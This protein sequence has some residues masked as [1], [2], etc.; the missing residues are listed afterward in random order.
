MDEKKFDEIVFKMREDTFAMNDEEATVVVDEY[1][2]E[3]P[4]LLSMKTK[5]WFIKYC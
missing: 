2:E 5:E 3:Y 4:S 1:I